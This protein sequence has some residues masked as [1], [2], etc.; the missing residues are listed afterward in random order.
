MSQYHIDCIFG[1]ENCSKSNNKKR[2]LS[3]DGKE[4][5]LRKQVQHKENATLQRWKIAETF[6]CMRRKQQQ[7]QTLTF[8]LKIKVTQL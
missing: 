8:K 5:K 3:T 2:T 1:M 4:K 6:M 7:Q